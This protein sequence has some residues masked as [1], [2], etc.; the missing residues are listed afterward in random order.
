MFNNRCLKWVII[1]PFLSLITCA[2]HAFYYQTDQLPEA[3]QMHGAAVVGNHLYV[4]GG[5]TLS[6]GYE[7]SVMKAQ[8]LPD[9]NVQ[10]WT[11]TTPMPQVRAYISNTT[12]VL[13]DVLY[14]LC[15]FDGTQY[16]K[17]MIWT[18]AQPDGTLLPWKES[19]PI[20][21]AGV[22]C[23][24]A[25]ST[26]GHIYL[27]GGGSG[28]PPQP[29]N[30]VLVG[31][32]NE[33]GDFVRWE[34]GPSLPVS[35]WFHNAAVVSGRI[36]VWNGLTTGSPSSLNKNIYSAP[37]RSDGS[38][39][40]W[41][42]EFVSIPQPLYGAVGTSCG[43]YL[44]SFCGRYSS[45]IES[46]DVWFCSVTDAGLTPW[47]RLETTLDTRLYH[48]LATDYRRGLV[49]VPGGRFIKS[50]N[51]SL[52]KSVYYFKLAQKKAEA[53]AGDGASAKTN[54]L[55]QGSAPSEMTYRYQA[56]L[57]ADAIQ[58]FMSYEQARNLSR[59]YNR[60][61]VVY[62][63]SPD[64]RPCQQQQQILSQFNIASYGQQILFAWVDTTIA[65]QLV[66]QIGVFRVPCWIF[67]DRTRQEKGRNY[68]MLNA[69]TLTSKLDG[70]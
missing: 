29:V 34:Q 6:K 21:G 38:I 13:N 5:N 61:L 46:S 49:Y 69:E 19:A 37:L 39:G 51:V 31:V 59:Q 10:Q 41:R 60:P 18:R 26:P 70:L 16:W 3:R 43:S 52:R 40:E 9:G 15:G 45:T 27:I 33:N 57:P 42:Q 67:Y 8:I 47:Q 14:V 24:A 62:F 17:T 65:P 30:T 56:T 35:L 28:K 36:W 1:L 64:V 11:K 53:N 4:L 55:Y 63:H 22:D 32:L 20:P 25:A 68:G 12:I 50:D 23:S 7:A 58:G 2:S 54:T 48:A 66:Q 44:I